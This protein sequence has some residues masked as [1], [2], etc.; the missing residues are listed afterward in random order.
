MC[1]KGTMKTPTIIG[2][3][4]G[5]LHGINDVTLDV[6][7]LL[8]TRLLIQANSGGGKSY[9][10]RRLCEQ[11][12]GKV[13]VIVIDRE[14]EFS[15]LRE[16]YGYVLVGKDGDTPADVRSA[17]LLARRLLELNASAVC[18]IYDMSAGPQHE[19]VK[20]FI[21]A[22]VNAPKKLRHPCVVIVDEAHLF[23]CE[24][25]HGES[26]AKDAMIDLATLGRKRGLCAV[27]ATQRLG[28]LAKSAASELQNVMI[29]A[30]SLDI[31]RKRCSDALGIQKKDERRFFADIKAMEPGTFYAQGRAISRDCITVNV[32]PVET[33]HPEVGKHTAVPPVVPENVRAL[34]PQLE[35]LPHEA[36][37]K[38]IT[39]KELRQQV[40]TLTKQLNSVETA[41]KTYVEH[42]ARLA[43]AER[44]NAKPVVDADAI[45]KA[46]EQRD[47]EYAAHTVQVTKAFNEL[48]EAT[49]SRLAAAQAAELPQFVTSQPVA[50]TTKESEFVS[51][52]PLPKVETRYYVDFPRTNHSNT[53]EK[54]PKGEK[55]ILIACAQY[56][57]G[58]TREQLTIFTGQKR[59]T[60][61][62]YIQRV[63]QR[64]Y[65]VT[66][67]LTI[68][69]TTDGIA[70]LGSG[71]TPLPTGE[72]LRE[73]WLQRLPEGERSV[74][75]SLITVYPLIETREFVTNETGYK[76]STRDAYLQRLGSK[77]LVEFVGRGEVKA[78]AQLFN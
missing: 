15:T 71:Y 11:L 20:K 5:V 74:L 77:R 16:K 27:F 60:R 68:Q 67:G 57:D 52:R 10:L 33:S 3:Q 23:A 56:P 64:G 50:L 51:H 7:V 1:V 66:D 69:A 55:Q 38:E 42:V 13:Q 31:D 53:G 29:G 62:A 75:S 58:L 61:D 21:N 4:P 6:D 49:V 72:A 30:T 44:D 22:L 45:A 48:K 8:A 70:A 28:K 37:T 18:D 36:E 63:S 39:E 78:S 26:V 17:D 9:L 34:L 41:H 73:Y 25:G 24:K 76:R 14:G 46:L 19:W 12:Y 2:T 59:S 54:I 47:R 40:A 32:G 65:V 43:Q 35:D